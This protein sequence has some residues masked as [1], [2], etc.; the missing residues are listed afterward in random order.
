MKTVSVIPFYLPQKT[1]LH[2][3]HLGV[4]LALV[5]AYAATIFGVANPWG[6]SIILFGLAAVTIILKLPLTHWLPTLIGVMLPLLPAVFPILDTEPLTSIMISYMR[7]VSFLLLL[8][9]FTMTTRPMFVLQYLFRSK[10]L[11]PF[12]QPGLY[13][14]NTMLAVFPSLEYD[15]QRAVE[16]EKIRLG[17]AVRLFDLG[18]W[19]TVLIVTLTR[20]LNRAERFADSVIDRGFSPHQEVTFFHERAASLADWGVLIGAVLPCLLIW[21][22]LK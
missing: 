14:L 15:L 11:L 18:S 9:L 20:A 5:V 10:R 4:K 21:G 6:Q 8:S 13:I 16:A 12:I 22:V 7:I 19:M 17:R 2:H 1:L 3:L